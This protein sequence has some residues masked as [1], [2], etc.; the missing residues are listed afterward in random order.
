MRNTKS[1]GFTLIELLIVIAIIGILAAVL[2]PN[3]LNARTRAFDTAAQTCLKELATQEEILAS[4]NPWQYSSNSYTKAYA[5]AQFTL[6]PAV[7]DDPLTV[8][9][10]ETAP[11]VVDDVQSCTNVQVVATAHTDAAS[12]AGPEAYYSYGGKH[13]NGAN[14]YRIE[15][16]SGVQVDNGIAG[17]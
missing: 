3:L 12:F 9:V 11:A 7:A 5:G 4:V 15:L 1:G 6:Q 13:L 17:F 8:G 16:G 2:I 10:D 14:I